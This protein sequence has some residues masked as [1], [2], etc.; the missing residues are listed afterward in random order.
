MF[1]LY[2][3]IHNQSVRKSAWESYSD[4]GYSKTKLTGHLTRNLRVIVLDLDG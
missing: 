2:D 3:A 1:R 4:V